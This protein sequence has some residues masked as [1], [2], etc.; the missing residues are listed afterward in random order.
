VL[1]PATDGLPFA[2]R[3]RA[4]V[5]ARAVSTELATYPHAPQPANHDA[6]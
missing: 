5:T 4:Y 6:L 2:S 1:P 3:N